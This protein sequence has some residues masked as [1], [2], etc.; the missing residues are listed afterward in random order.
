[1]GG[2]IR[3][4]PMTH[5]PSVSTDCPQI[6]QS[7]NPIPASTPVEITENTSANKCSSVVI[8]CCRRKQSSSEEALLAHTSAQAQPQVI[9]CFERAQDLHVASVGRITKQ[10]A[11]VKEQGAGISDQNNAEEGHCAGGQAQGLGV[12]EE[13]HGGAVLGAEGAKETGEENEDAARADASGENLR[14]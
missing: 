4:V 10:G 3:H 11:A 9:V 1:M 7:E 2:G 14:R 12:R 5:P 8:Q 13:G 6:S